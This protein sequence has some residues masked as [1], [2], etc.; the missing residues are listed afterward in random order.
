MRCAGNLEGIFTYIRLRG[1]VICGAL[2]YALVL[3]GCTPT[4]TDKPDDSTFKSS[5]SILPAGKPGLRVQSTA[6][7]S[8]EPIPADFTGKGD[9]KSPDL[10][11]SPGPKGTEAY[12][13]LVED[14]DALKETAFIHWML[15]D[16]PSDRTKI[17]SSVSDSTTVGYG[18]AL[19]GTNDRG[20]MGY[21]GPYPT[22][23][24]KMHHYHFRVFALS[25]RLRLSPGFDSRTFAAAIKG[26]VLAEGELVGTVERIDR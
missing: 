3:A 26:H 17:E 20:G 15:A 9:S 19:T 4:K 18:G 12:A 16:I 25:Q 13:V 23:G 5:P 2:M 6:F 11:W 14:P 10:E 22:A 24:P 8:G 21:V 1:L 7:K